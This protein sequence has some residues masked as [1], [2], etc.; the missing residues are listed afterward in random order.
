MN[1]IP[2]GYKQTDIG[3]IPAEWDVRSLKELFELKN[4][5]NTDKRNYGFGIKF[6]NV[7]EVIKKDILYYEDIPGFISLSSGT[8]KNYLVKKGDILFNRTSETQE[9]IGLTAVYFDDK[10]VV[11]GGFVIRGRPIDNSINHSYSKYAFSSKIVRKEIIKRGQG[12]IR[13]NIG[14]GDLYKVQIPLPPLS[15]Q[16]AIAE[17]LSDVDGL[18]SALDGL[19]AK[20]RNIKQG[21][22]QELLTGKRRLPGLS[23]SGKYKKTEVGILPEDWLTCDFID[24]V[25]KYIDYRGRTPKK[26]GMGW[27]GGEILALSAN[28]VEMGKI[29]LEKEANYCSEI[30]YKKWM[31]HGDCENGDVLLTMEAPLGNVAQIP[32]NNKYVLSQRVLLIRPNVFILKDYFSYFLKS[33]YFQN[34]LI[35]NSSG[36]TAQGIQRKKLDKI[37]IFYPSSILEQSAIAAILSDMDAEIEQLEHKR[38]K[39]KQAKQGMMQE[40]LTGK[41][42]LI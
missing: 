42:R 1:K 8:I 14:Q 37:R 33:K 34:Q 20:K 26:M 41:T 24:S 5:V 4:G 19:I 23:K 25:G 31:Q 30:L 3:V 17:A 39:Y 28:N 21:T 13:A 16:S 12:V 11:F 29:N 40:L 18:I 2:K 7:L 38:D 36:T 6:I 15:E 22:M 9:E 32:D 35:I 27:G 10:E